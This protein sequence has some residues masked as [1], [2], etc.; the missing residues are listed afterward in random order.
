MARRVSLLLV[1]VLPVLLGGCAGSS[2]YMVKSE[3]P[4]AGPPPDKSVVYVMRPSG[5]GFAVN[6]QVWDRDRLIGVSQAKSYFAYVCDPGK[7][8]FIGIAENKVAVDADLAPGKSY[9]II[10]EPRMGGWK[11]RLAM[12][13]V[14][15][16]S[17]NWD[18]VEGLKAE[19]EYVVPV[20]EEIRTWDSA[21]KEVVV[22][23]VNF[24]EKD[25]D[26]EK[27]MGRLVPDDGR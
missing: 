16:G 10:T 11:A 14:S 17:E 24:F 21:K 22:G 7:H 25:P 23:L 20:E 27:Y 8:L 6:F 26:R 12:T 13:P 9:Y 1:V 19:M 18:K 5:F 15:K 3:P 4:K 2:K